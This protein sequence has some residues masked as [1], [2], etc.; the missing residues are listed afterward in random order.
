MMNL[1]A[2][3]AGVPVVSTKSGGIPEYVVDGENGILVPERDAKSL[4]DAL[5]KLLADEKLR[6]SMGKNAR[7]YALEHYSDKKNIEKAEKILLEMIK[8]E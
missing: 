5:I 4:G 7:D 2:M 1:E 8:Y 3:S 6:Q